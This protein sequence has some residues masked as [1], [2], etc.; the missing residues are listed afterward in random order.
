M[1]RRTEVQIKNKFRNWPCFCGSGVKFKECCMF[2]VNRKDGGV[3]PIRA[4]DIMFGQM[5]KKR[6][7]S[8]IK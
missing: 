4:V 8:N 3:L 2:D 6:E 1:K 5:Q 7:R